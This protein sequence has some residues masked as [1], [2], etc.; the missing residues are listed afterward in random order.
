MRL[1]KSHDVGSIPTGPASAVT[2][3][4]IIRQFFKIL[5]VI[6]MTWLPDESPARN[7]IFS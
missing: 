1:S 6:I 3:N 4:P 5:M 2:V 7:Q